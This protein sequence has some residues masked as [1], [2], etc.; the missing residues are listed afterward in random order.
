MRRTRKKKA[1]SDKKKKIP[2][3]N[4][5]DPNLKR[6]NRGVPAR[7]WS[8][9]KKTLL[10]RPSFFSF[11]FLLVYHWLYTMMLIFILALVFIVGVFWSAV[12]PALITAGQHNQPQGH[13]AERGEHDRVRRDEVAEERHLRGVDIGPIDASQSVVVAQLL[14][15]RLRRRCACS[16]VRVSQIGG[17]TVALDIA[18]LRAITCRAV[19]PRTGAPVELRVEY[20]RGR[21]T[22]VPALSSTT[23]AS[24]VHQGCCSRGCELGTARIGPRRA[25]QNSAFFGVTSRIRSTPGA[26]RD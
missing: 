11:F 16:H 5:S 18:V 19:L 2:Q 7:S 17:D 21:T 23:W 10:T 6:K 14:V 20:I 22:Q 15:V 26:A 24:I 9:P 3:T 8:R 13:E 12:R 4:L 1:C 25:K